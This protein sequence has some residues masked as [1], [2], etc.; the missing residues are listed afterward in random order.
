MAD[1]LF[2][3]TADIAVGALQKMLL[4]TGA[5]NFGLSLLAF[6]NL[7][8]VMAPAVSLLFFVIIGV[9]TIRGKL[10]DNRLKDLKIKEIEERHLTDSVNE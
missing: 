3:H 10:K 4:L 2:N 8:P 7:V 1:G 5:G 9:I 6:L